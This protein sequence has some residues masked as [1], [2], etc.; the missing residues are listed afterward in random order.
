MGHAGVFAAEYYAD[1]AVATSGSGSIGAPF[2]SIQEGLDQLGPGD[3]LWI[4]GSAAGRVYAETPT[5]GVSGTASQPIALKA[6]PGEKV[7]LTGTSGTR[8]NLTKDYWVI[9]GITIDQA[10][11]PADCVRINASHVTIQGC[12]I[13]NGQREGISI[14]RGS[15]ITIQDCLIHDFVWID[16]GARVDAHCIQID[17]GV[18]TTVTGVTIQR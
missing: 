1:N 17:S 3:V 5:L 7:I 9:D 16:N 10:N 8:I 11:I 2:G 13:M 15:D 18:S 12:E 14:E 6:Y 4:R